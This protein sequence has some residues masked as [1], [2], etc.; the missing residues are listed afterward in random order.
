MRIFLHWRWGVS[1]EEVSGGGGAGGRGGQT[2]LL[3]RLWARRLIC[4]RSRDLDGGRSRAGEEGH[5][6]VSHGEPGRDD[7]DD[8]GCDALKERDC[9]E[10]RGG[11]VGRGARRVER[12][13]ESTPPPTRTCSLSAS[14]TG[15]RQT[16][17]T[18]CAHNIARPRPRSRRPPP[19][20]PR[21]PAMAGLARDVA[22][23]KSAL[24]RQDYTSWH[25]QP[26]PPQPAQHPSSS[27]SGSA[28]GD[29]KKKKRPKSSMYGPLSFPAPLTSCARHCILST[30]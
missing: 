9:D 13:L 17:P 5:V 29:S 26:P 24:H 30:R 11:R 20:P 3:G 16:P 6:A 10:R 18:T 2:R 1:A 4:G 8:R 22:A 23:F 14:H 28:D 7:G 25:S 21:P 19:R 27:A 12:R 15:A